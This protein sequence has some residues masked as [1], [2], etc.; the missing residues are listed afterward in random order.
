MRTLSARHSMVLTA[1]SSDFPSILKH[2][3]SRGDAA[4]SRPSDSD[5][6]QVH[7]AGRQYKLRRQRF[8]ADEKRFYACGPMRPDFRAMDNSQDRQPLKIASHFST[9]PMAM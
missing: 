8:Y 5:V 6:A 9:G 7:R 3:R 2:S 1:T 4:V